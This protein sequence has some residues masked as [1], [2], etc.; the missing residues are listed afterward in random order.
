MPTPIL[1]DTFTSIT[2]PGANTELTAIND[3]CE[4]AGSYLL[5][6]IGNY[7]FAYDHGTFTTPT[8]PSA[9]GTFAGAI[10]DRGEVAGYDAD[11]SFATHGF[12]L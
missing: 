1:S 2:E 10:N 12:I 6:G 3:R 7:G 8:V 11:S 5:Q 4:V 9:L